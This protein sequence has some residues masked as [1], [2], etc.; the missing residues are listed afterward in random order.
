MLTE[1]NPKFFGLAK[2]TFVFCLRKVIQ[3]MNQHC[4]GHNAQMLQNCSPSPAWGVLRQLPDQKWILLQPSL[5]RSSPNPGH[6]PG[7]GCSCSM[8]GAEADSPGGWHGVLG[9]GEP[10]G[11]SRDSQGSGCPWGPATRFFLGQIS[12]LRDFSLIW[13]CWGSFAP[14]SSALPDLA[15]L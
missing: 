14:S 1:I 3:A 6:L 4:H 10:Q 13:T 8:A 5:A 15:W 2:T 7:D 11:A 9:C 12:V